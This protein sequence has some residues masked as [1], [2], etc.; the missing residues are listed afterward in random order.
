MNKINNKEKNKYIFIEIINFFDFEK[1]LTNQ[2][3]R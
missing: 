3:K 1:K 2:K